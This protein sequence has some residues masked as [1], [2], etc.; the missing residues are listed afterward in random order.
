MNKIKIM[1]ISDLHSWDFHELESISEYD[2]DICVLCGDIPVN[3]IKA[4]RS[5]VKNRPVIAVAGN[6][7]EWD[8]PDLGGA[9]N[10]HLKQYSYYGFTMFGFGGSFRYK[11]GNYPMFTQQECLSALKGAPKADILVS[12]DSMYR[13]FGKNNAHKGLIGITSYIFNNRVKLNICGHHHMNEVKQ[14]FGCTVVCVYRCSLITYPDI[15]VTN[16]F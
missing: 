5:I 10:I 11:H 1:A 2:F 14:R 9:E 6:H 13:L 4:I 16:I 3:A 12:H 15:S 7:D 8:N